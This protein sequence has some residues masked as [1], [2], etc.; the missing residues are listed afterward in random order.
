MP[1]SPK[2]VLGPN[3]R[4]WSIT[5]SARLISTCGNVCEPGRLMPIE[6]AVKPCC[7]DEYAFMRV[8]P[9]CCSQ[10]RFGDKMTVLAREMTWLPAESCWGK[11]SSEPE[12]PKGSLVGSR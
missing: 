2:L 4:A 12:A 1:P 7:V 11:P 9:K 3:S 6:L 5:G 10:V 8:N